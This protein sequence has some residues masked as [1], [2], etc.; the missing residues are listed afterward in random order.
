MSAGH[1]LKLTGTT[2]TPFKHISVSAISP[3]I[4]AMISGIDSDLSLTKSGPGKEI[5][6]EIERALV[7]HLVVFFRQ[8]TLEPDE[9]LQLAR[10]FGVPTTYPFVDGIPGFP[11][12][13]EVL[14]L[15]DEKENFGGV[16][17]SDTA[18]LETPAMGALLYARELPPSGGDTLFANM[19]SAYERLSPGLQS[20]LGSLNAVFDADKS[21]I[22]ETRVNRVSG[23][24][25]NLKAVHPVVRTHPVT[26][27]KLLYVNRAHTTHFEGMSR[28]ES[29]GLLDYLFDIQALDEISCRF[30]WQPGSL[31]L[32]DNRACQHYPLNDYSGHKRLMH[33]I[34]LLGDR[35]C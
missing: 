31:A 3:H 1:L 21:E 15:P 33:R 32:W 25:K 30:H 19:Y 20:F 13:V 2:I 18:Y 35:P 9:F 22:S 5:V 7:I 6:A 26:R 24:R 4:G 17:H 14:K 34:S 23:S 27:R 29:Q 12:I 16:W 11:E 8:Q 28:A 10:C